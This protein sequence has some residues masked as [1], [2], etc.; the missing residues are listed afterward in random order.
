ME[1]VRMSE[2]V[3]PDRLR[4]TIMTRLPGAVIG[5]VD[6]EIKLDHGIRQIIGHF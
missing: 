5:P 6:L 2:Y 4:E 3:A 1:D